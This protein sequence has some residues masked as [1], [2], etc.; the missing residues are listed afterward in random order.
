MHGP[1]LCSGSSHDIPCVCVCVCVQRFWR[2]LLRV[3]LPSDS[4]C[5]MRCA[6][7]GL[8]D[9]SYQQ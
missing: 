5:H 4:L 2:F 7:L 6:V 3:N 9:S 1:T 8:G